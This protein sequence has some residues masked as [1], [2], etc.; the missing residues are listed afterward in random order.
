MSARSVLKNELAIGKL[1]LELGPG[2]AVRVFLV[3]ILVLGAA[4]LLFCIVAFFVVAFSLW[5]LPV[6]IAL[7]ALALVAG[8][9]YIYARK[10]ERSLRLNPRIVNASRLLLVVALPLLTIGTGIQ[11]VT[12][13][14]ELRP[15][16]IASAITLAFVMSRLSAQ[17]AREETASDMGRL[18]VRSAIAAALATDQASR[19]ITTVD[20]KPTENTTKGEA[21][22]ALIETILNRAA[23]LCGRST[24]VEGN[25]RAVFYRLTDSG[26]LT[27]A[28]WKGRSGRSPR[29]LFDPARNA[30]DRGVLEIAKGEDVLL[31]RDVDAAPVDYFEDYEGRE[32]KSTITVPVRCEGRAYGILAVDSNKVNA[33]SDVDVGFMMLLATNLAR[34]IAEIE[35]TFLPT[36]AKGSANDGRPSRRHPDKHSDRVRTEEE[37]NVVTTPLLSSNEFGLIEGT[38]SRDE[39]VDRVRHDTAAAARHGW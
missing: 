11:S 25:S 7:A 15:Y 30:N 32:Y 29:R 26:M 38:L 36:S 27:L 39:Y 21:E 10:S 12:G 23:S 16:Y 6:L 3:R 1:P 13:E 28:G 4:V 34:G 31:V 5:P 37:P 2:R 24:E 35:S 22:T 17:R 20:A 8:G 19:A 14:G 9:V 18:A 33:F